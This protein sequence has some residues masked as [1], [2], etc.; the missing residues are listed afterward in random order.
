MTISNH[1]QRKCYNN[2]CGER[3]Y[4]QHVHERTCEPFMSLYRVSHDHAFLLATPAGYEQAKENNIY[5]HGKQ[6]T[7][8]QNF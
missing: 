1:T 5:R 6:S 8:H 3:R 7:Q 2:I 4:V